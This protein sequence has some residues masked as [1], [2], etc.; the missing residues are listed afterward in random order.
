MRNVTTPLV[1]IRSARHDAC[2]GSA[3][4]ASACGGL[5]AYRADL[6]DAS[7]PDVDDIRALVLAAFEAAHRK[8]KPDWHQ[9]TLAVLKNRLLQMTNGGFRVEDYAVETL[10][11]FVGRVPDLV[12]FDAG[13]PSRVW[14]TERALSQVQS[15]TQTFAPS[16]G[17]KD[18][19]WKSIRIRDDLWK[20]I[21]DFA[22][23]ELYVWDSVDQVVRPRR[24]TDGVEARDF[25]TLSAQEFEGWRA[26]WVESIRGD[27]G[28]G[29]EQSLMSDWADG[30]GRVTDLPPRL[31]GKYLEWF[32]KRITARLEQWFAS[33]GLTLPEDIHVLTDARAISTAS[34][35]G[36]HVRNQSVREVVEEQRLRSNV[37]RAVGL[38]TFDELKSLQLPASVITRLL[39]RR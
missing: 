18:V 36:E 39:D 31:R 12:R 24:V 1:S 2:F 21:V 14:L 3:P 35:S 10:A 19:D 37:T 11:Q 9:M 5:G 25:P 27:L 30:S 28:G 7:M 13:P 32:K 17:E 29:A 34:I 26:D 33:H 4:W 22:G 20:G 23:P 6:Y 38:M 16:A 8:K 15:K